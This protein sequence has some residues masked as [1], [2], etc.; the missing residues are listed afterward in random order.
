MAVAC[1]GTVRAKRETRVDHPNPKFD[2]WFFSFFQHKLS[3]TSPA[4]LRLL[5]W[6]LV[7]KMLFPG[8][9]FPVVPLLG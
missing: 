4:L 1:K 5:L 7:V 6:Y 8:K 3:H 9:V 2:W